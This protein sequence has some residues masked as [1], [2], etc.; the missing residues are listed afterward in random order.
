MMATVGENIARIRGEMDAAA[1]RGGRD[2]A[3]ARLM[4]V[5]KT[6]SP[7]AV[8][9]AYDAGLRL[10]GENYVQ[11]GLLKIETLPPDAE[12]RMIGHLQSNKAKKAARSFS[13]VD[14]VD[15]P[16]LAEELNRAANALGRVL[17][18]L[19]EVNLGDEDT[20]S[21]CDREGALSLARRAAEWPA[22]SIRG[23]M[24]LPPYLADPEAVR[25]YFRALKELSREIEVLNLPGVSMA[26]LSMGMSHD[27]PVAVEEGATIVRVGTAIFGERIYTQKG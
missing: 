6:V 25:P 2:P 19:I 14:S 22:L 13:A 27:F 5:T 3:S 26:E 12:W 23:L 17:P 20:K 16:S 10:F 9:L 4:A 8:R 15:R 24:A 21:G 18:V 11:E 7:V 1:R